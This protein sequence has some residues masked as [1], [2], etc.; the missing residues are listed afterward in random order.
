[1]AWGL[2]SD[3]QCNVPGSAQQGV[4]LI[5]AGIQHSMAARRD[6]GYPAIVSGPRIIGAPETLIEHQVQ[7]ADA[8]DSELEFSAIGLPPGLSLIG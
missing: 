5:A 4:H 3:G 8:G 1:M 2:N 6:A 7:V